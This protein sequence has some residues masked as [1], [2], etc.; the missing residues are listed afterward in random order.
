MSAVNVAGT[1]EQEQTARMNKLLESIPG[2]MNTLGV[3][4]TMVYKLIGDG[5]LVRVNI[6]TRSFITTES[7]ARYVERLTEAATAGVCV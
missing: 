7:I 3:G 5:H 2:T 4:R 1:D 6:G